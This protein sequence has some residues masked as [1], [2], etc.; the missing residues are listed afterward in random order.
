MADKNRPRDRH[1]LMPVRII[2][3]CG[4]WLGIFNWTDLFSFVLARSTRV[5]RLFSNNAKLAVSGR[6]DAGP[7]A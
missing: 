1:N 5:S 6:L 7:F 4:K 3:A 2:D